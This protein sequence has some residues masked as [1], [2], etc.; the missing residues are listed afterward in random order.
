MNENRFI[1]LHPIAGSN[2]YSPL[3]VNVNNIVAFWDENG[4]AKLL[5]NCMEG[6]NTITSVESYE[7]V[8]SLLLANS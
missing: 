3:Y 6:N 1:L 4:K 5:L 7:D 2:W 8:L